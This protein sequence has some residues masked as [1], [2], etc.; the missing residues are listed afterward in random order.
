MQYCNKLLLALM[1]VVIVSFL[2][3]V[4]E[5]YYRRKIIFG[6]DHDYPPYQFVDEQGN[7]VGSD[8]DIV[9][10]IARETGLEIEIRPM[11]WRDCLES[12]NDGSIDAL[13]GM[14]YTLER[15]HHY[16]FSL[17]HN[18]INISIIKRK[19]NQHITSESDIINRQIVVQK[20]DIMYEHLQ[21][22]NL[23][24]DL[25]V[26]DNQIEAIKLIAAGKY[27][28]ALLPEVQ[29]LYFAEKHG[30]NNIEAAGY[31]YSLEY[32][33]VS[34]PDNLELI[35]IINHGLLSLRQS[36]ELQ[37]ILNNWFSKYETEPMSIEDIFRY[38]LIALIVITFTFFLFLVWT[39]SLRTKIQKSTQELQQELNEHQKTTQKLNDSIDR[40]LHLINNLSEIVFEIDLKGN[41]LYANHSINAVLG[42]E[43]DEVMNA[44]NL[45][46][47][48]APSD[49]KLLAP[50]Y[51]E[52]ISSKK[53]VLTLSGLSKDKKEIPLKI[54][55]GIIHKKDG[56][57]HILAII[58]DYSAQKKHQLLTN[59]LYDI[60]E[61]SHVTENI[62][63]L[64][65][66]IHNL[67]G[68]LMPVNNLYISLY[69]EEKDI[70]SFPYFIA[71]AESQPKPK[72]FGKGMT[73]YVIRKGEA[74]LAT[75]EM[76]HDLHEKGD[77]DDLRIPAEVWIGVPLVSRG[78]VIGV[79]AVQ[80]YNNPDTYNESD[81]QVLTFVSEQIASAI[82]R[83]TTEEEILRQKG[84]FE[85]LFNNIPAGV[86]LV[87][88]DDRIINVNQTFLDMFEY[89]VNEVIGSK[90]NNLVVPENLIDEAANFSAATQ[91]GSAIQTETIRRSK[92]G[93]LLNVRLFGIPVVIDGTEEA[94]YGIYFNITELQKAKESFEDEK[95][96]FRVMLASIG[97][98]V[99]ATDSRGRVV[100]INQI[101]CNLTGW[102]QEEALNKPVEAVF[103]IVNE[104]TGE[105]I[106]GLV[107]KVIDTGEVVSISNNT[108]LKSGDGKEYIIE[109]SAAPI[110]DKNR[111]LIGVI[112]VFRDATEKKRLE[113]ELQRN[114]KLDSIGILAAG[115]AHDF[116]NIL[117]SITGNLAMAHKHALEYDYNNVKVKVKEAEKSALRARNLT[118]QLLTY[119]KGGEPVKTTSSVKEILEETIDFATI[120]SSVA[121]EID[122]SDDLWN[123][124]ADTGQIGQ[125]IN[126]LVINAV[127][128]MPRGGVLTIKGENIKLRSA[129]FNILDPGKYVLLTVKDTGCGIDN[130]TLNNIFDPFFTTK[131]DGTGLGLTTCNNI[132]RKHNGY[133]T[134][135]TAV[136]K[137][138]LFTVYLPATDKSMPVKDEAAAPRRQKGNILIMDDDDA[139]R[140]IVKEMLE[141]LGHS[142]TAVIKGEDAIEAY[143]KELENNSRFDIV[144]LDLTVPGGM[145][146]LETVRHI[147][148]IDPHACCI[149]SS[150]YAS[151]PV[152]S[153]YAEYGF[154]GVLSKPYSFEE[155]AEI[156]SRTL[157]Q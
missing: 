25:I 109:D 155:M 146:G 119:S 20:D 125:V 91:L 131:S 123:I 74:V 28:A 114:S 58:V 144:I 31:I 102:K 111:T 133:M 47:V 1:A 132:V 10:A 101:A 150:G 68:K 30:F 128:A 4:T 112:L 138:T 8:I 104:T 77:L 18:H 59:V 72:K 9:K 19:D 82:I 83:K 71:E 17:P 3:G 122:I 56:V 98:G 42:Y 107:K 147:L 87:G 105:T 129:K 63:D 38:I 118:N 37:E 50:F 126:N 139:L 110:I 134:V 53:S 108:V 88:K 61:A 121:K 73:E 85:E 64:F 76:L 80:D 143:R 51:E 13:V 78:K 41:I 79:I 46:D 23:K 60:S 67:V 75:K 151:D 106:A 90:V 145:G 45:R 86:V 48:I 15:A 36:G 34:L 70:L 55:A 14:V 141:T 12:L 6:S 156:I 35:T 152:M 116:N 99:I 66:T 137:G 136:G 93:N 120:G 100:L 40:Y 127:Q 7:P 29:A 62:D 54:Y 24:E 96:R 117:T 49:R 52:I 84:N 154:N 43:P 103:Q 95:E 142:V 69:D 32:G 33:I 27:D 16:C 113:I 97:D 89:P 94:I 130:E 149:V 2:N 148:S 5:D 11:V 21:R 140:S 65:K 92:S 26:V 115:I 157:N 39:I 57:P 135:D 44:L 124:E 22:L 153:N 81:K